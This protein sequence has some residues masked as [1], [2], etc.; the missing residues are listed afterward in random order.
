MARRIGHITLA[1]V[2][3]LRAT[4]WQSAQTDYIRRLEHYTDF[5]LIEVRDMVGKLALDAVAVAKEGEMLLAAARGRRTILLSEDGRS[6][7]SRELADNLR[8]QLEQFGQLVFLI[9]GP[10]GFDTAVKLA[11]HDN[12]ALS[13]LTFPHELARILLLEQLYRA[14]TIIHGEPYHK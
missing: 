12:W 13:S 10:I 11:A 4:H 8:N 1:A 6:Q 5:N 9:G 3:K 14:F 7:S 2:G